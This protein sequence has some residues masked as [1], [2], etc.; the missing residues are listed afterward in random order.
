MII[1]IVPKSFEFEASVIYCF[2]QEGKLVLLKKQIED[3]LYPGLCGFVA[4]RIKTDENMFSA[5]K[6]EILEETGNEKDLQ[7]LIYLGK[8]F[9]TRHHTY[10]T[11]QPRIFLAHM[12]L[13]SEPLGQIIISREHSKHYLVTESDILAEKF[14]CIPDAID[15]FRDCLPIIR[16]IKGEMTNKKVIGII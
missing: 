3:E 9:P 11:G 15:N 16:R 13:C 12:M 10:K 4:G 1:K 8:S 5:A 7:S 14:N 2:N 6:R